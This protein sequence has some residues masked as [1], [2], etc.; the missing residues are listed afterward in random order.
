MLHIDLQKLG[1]ALKILP[2]I[3]QN[4]VILLQTDYFMAK[5]YINNLVAVT[6][7]LWEE[8]ALN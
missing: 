6:Q 5:F 7:D 4:H 8:A 3:L 2:D 1:V